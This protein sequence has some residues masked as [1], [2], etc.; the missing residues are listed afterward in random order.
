MDHFSMVLCYR[1][2]TIVF[3]ISHKIIMEEK[4]EALFDNSQSESPVFQHGFD[5]LGKA[6]LFSVIWIRHEVCNEPGLARPVLRLILFWL[7]VV[8]RWLFYLRSL[9]FQH[10]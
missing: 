10:R 1:V 6:H 8:P 7:A 9:A 4:E 5:N 2:G 3:I